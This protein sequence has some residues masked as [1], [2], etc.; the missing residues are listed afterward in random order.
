MSRRRHRGQSS[1]E[2]LALVPALV[3]LALGAWWLV[4]GAALWLQAGSAARVAAHAV[5]VD[6]EAPGAGEAPVRR[7]GPARIRAR[8][9]ADGVGRGRAEVVVPGPWGSPPVV[10]RAEAEAAGR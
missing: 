5:A 8:R 9:H 1:V 6:R 10:L 4:S 7:A 2:T 3:L